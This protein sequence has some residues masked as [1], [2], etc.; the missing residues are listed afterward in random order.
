MPEKRSLLATIRS[1][2]P[3]IVI[4]AVVLGPGSIFA[5]SQV[6]AIFGYS[7]VW[8]LVVAIILLIAMVRVAAH[9]GIVHEKTPCQE[10]AGRIGKKTAAA[11][12]VTLFLI[13]ACYQTS[14]NAAV[15]AAIEPLFSSDAQL[16]DWAP[17]AAVIGVN[18][19][20]L[21]ALYGF[22]ALYARIE[23]IMKG[24]VL[25]MI[26]A[27]LTNA[28]AAAPSLLKT[29]GGLIPLPPQPGYDVE[30]PYIRLQALIATTF[31][32]A[33]AFYQAYLV[34]ERGWTLSDS[35]KVR[36][37]SAFGIFVLG[38]MSL[39]IMITS[40]AVFHGL[41]KP[42]ELGT[43]TDV[44]RQLEPLFG[45]WA[46]VIFGLGIFAAALSSFLVNA[47]IGGCV[48]SDALGLGSRVGDR[49]PRHLTALALIL[50]MGVALYTAT[51]GVK[52]VQIITFAQALT[53]V[54]VPALAFALIYLATRPELSGERKLDRNTIALAYLGA[55]VAVVLA[56][57]TAVKVIASFFQ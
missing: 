13:I 45:S 3:A 17:V 36:R 38:A 42:P 29:L 18:V 51:T 37:D 6:G 10:I 2:G 39:L 8:V 28:I 52:V 40:A 11:I 15:T 32:V 23:L 21:L 26:L 49:W 46:K 19:I 16:P 30:D 14:N 54:G 43:A 41:D 1:V 7:A 34:R 24:L 9:V 50:S 48:L 53:V 57:R 35:D 31:S 33:A 56:L 4:A 20:A 22:R 5:S 25:V 12:G 55:A 27:F 44:A 47:M